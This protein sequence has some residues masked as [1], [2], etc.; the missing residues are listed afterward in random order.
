M[1]SVLIISAVVVLVDGVFMAQV[2]TEVREQYSPF[3]RNYVPGAGVVM[4]WRWW[5]G[6]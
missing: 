3:F 4:W 5:N 1:F 6:E 2:P